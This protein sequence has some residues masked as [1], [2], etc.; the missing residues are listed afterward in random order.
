MVIKCSFLSD[1]A[2]IRYWENG[3]QMLSPH[4]TGIQDSIMANLMPQSWD[5]NTIDTEPCAIDI[6]DHLFKAYVNDVVDLAFKGYVRMKR[7]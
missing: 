5:T 7:A 1:L 6:T 3:C 2:E 4:D